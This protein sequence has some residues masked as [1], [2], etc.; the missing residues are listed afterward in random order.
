MAVWGAA[1]ALVAGAD[2]QLVSST[3]Q[4]TGAFQNLP[5][6]NLLQVHFPVDI[7]HCILP[8]GVQKMEE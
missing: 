3:A 4:G 7:L 5:E 8:V 1:L 6:T 2:A